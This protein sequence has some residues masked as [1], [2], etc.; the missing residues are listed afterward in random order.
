MP[1]R[2]SS[3]VPYSWQVLLGVL[4]GATPLSA[5]FWGLGAPFAPVMEA[6]KLLGSAT[7]AVQTLVLASSLAA[8]LPK[9]VGGLGPDDD[10]ERELH[11]GTLWRVAGVRFLL[12]PL[13]GLA[14]NKVAL[15]LLSPQSRLLSVP[16]HQH[17]HVHVRVGAA[18]QSVF[19]PACGPHL[20]SSAAGERSV[21]SA[22]LVS[23]LIG[24][25]G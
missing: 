10:C 23:H 11:A 19:F 1:S 7:L 15:R 22:P 3:P 25:I 5:L 12:M 2:L 21:P 14:M 18:V 6:A 13:V 9:A 17:V 16:S 20:L 24:W 8:S 4:L